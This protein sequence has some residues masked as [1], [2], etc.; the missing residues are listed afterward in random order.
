MTVEIHKSELQKVVISSSNSKMFSHK[1]AISIAKYMQPDNI[2]IAVINF[3]KVTKKL[4]TDENPVDEIFC[5]M[6][7]I[8]NVTFLAP[9]NNLNELELLSQRNFIK[10]VDNLETK[11]DIIFLCAD[12]HH[13]ISLLRA[14]EGHKVFHITLA[15]V[16]H[17]KSN[18]FILMRNL[19]P[20][21]GLLYE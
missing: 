20:F 21:Q 17:T 12:N 7:E 11:Y 4:N 2:K 16:K 15:K 1:V 19:V 10:N 5:I 9:K 6:K 14:L 8:E 13:S 3:S 18:T